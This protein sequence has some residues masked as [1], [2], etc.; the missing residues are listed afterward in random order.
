MKTASEIQQA[1]QLSVRS[2]GRT[3]KG[4]AHEA[5][6]E[7]ICCVNYTGPGR[8]RGLYGIAEGISGLKTE[9]SELAI[10]TLKKCF[11]QIR[12]SDSFNGSS[13][14]PGCMKEVHA[15][16]EKKGVG[17]NGESAE[18][19]IVCAYLE[20]DMAHIAVAG[21]GAAYMMENGKI[22]RLTQ[23]TGAANLE[24]TDLSLMQPGQAP[25]G[26]PKGAFEPLFISQQMPP[27]GVL[28]LC[29]SGLIARVDP[30]TIQDTLAGASSLDEAADMLLEE[31]HRRDNSADVGIVLSR[32]ETP[33]EIKR[34]PA[35]ESVAYSGW[36][37]LK[38]Y[39]LVALLLAA[40]GM[41][42]VYG[43][44]KLATQQERNRTQK[45]EIQRTLPV[46]EPIHGTD[47]ET[48]TAADQGT[49][50]L[51]VSPAEA[52]VFI[53]GV[54]QPESGEYSIGLEAG[55]TSELRIEAAGFETYI[56]KITAAKDNTL[57]RYISL[58]LAK[59]K[60][61]SL[62]V[63]CQPECSSL[64]LDGKS[65]ESGFP[66]TDIMLREIAPGNHR[67][68]A[69][70]EGTTHGESLKIV[71]GVTQSVTFTFGGAKAKQTQTT[72]QPQKATQSDRTEENPRVDIVNTRPN[73]VE[74]AQ[75]SQLKTT[76]TPPSS[77]I[78]S[79]ATE[80][81][82]FRVDTNVTDCTVMVFKNNSLI[83]SGFS[84]TRFEVK[85]GRYTIRVSKPGYEEEQRDVTLANE[86]QVLQFDLRRQ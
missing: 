34:P 61:G 70:Y 2:S 9:A 66:R 77:S 57:E 73:N 58:K 53:D 21:G 78:S 67:V 45:T 26:F 28:L 43:T 24:N 44:N 72:L 36:L 62:L 40:I 85:P 80:A 10:E 17:E 30:I 42:I 47:E 76:R 37:F 41:I 25:A 27:R 79:P 83:D 8:A 23:D 22:S 20:G 5:N 19:S 35:R 84:G 56:E 51:K 15:A 18:A 55:R 46:I 64:T 4:A 33:I 39:L 52:R 59:P 54:Q 74:K 63:I 71:P 68:K 49:L 81:A 75:P 13:L 60:N 86:Y 14:L 32:L 31:A 7:Y 16:L 69:S 29:S 6:Y 38:K 65:V 48:K 1:T 50:S 11:K 3:L 82:F 12:D